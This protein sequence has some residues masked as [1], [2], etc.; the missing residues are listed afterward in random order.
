MLCTHT[1]D[2]EKRSI[3]TGEEAVKGRKDVEELTMVLGEGA[4]VCS[5]TITK[6]F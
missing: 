3:L 4:D 1:I 6:T 5:I 2:S